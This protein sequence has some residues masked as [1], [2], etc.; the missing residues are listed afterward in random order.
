[1]ALTINQQYSRFVEF[2]SQRNDTANQET[3]ARAG[4]LENGFLGGRAIKVAEGDRVGKARRSDDLQDANNLT[5]KLFR[6][7]I[8]DIFGGMSKIPASVKEAMKLKDYDQGKPLTVRRIMAVKSAIDVYVARAAE[9]FPRAQ[10]QATADGL[11]VGKM[12]APLDARERARIDKLVSTA[13]NAAVSDQDALELVVACGKDIVRGGDGSLRSEEQVKDRVAGIVAN[14]AELKAVAKGNQ[15]VVR[16]GLDFLKA[17]CGKPLPPG[18]IETFVRTTMKQSIG[19]I[20]AL[21]ADSDGIDLHKAVVQMFD[22]F[23]KAGEAADAATVTGREGDV[24]TRFR[25][26]S[27]QLMMIRLGDGLLPGIKTLLENKGS[28]LNSF[29]ADIAGDDMRFD[30]MDPV[31]REYMKRP[32][33]NYINI[34][35]SFYTELQV[36]QGTG[37]DDIKN[38][39]FIRNPNYRN[40]D[41]AGY[42][43]IDA[44][45]VAEDIRDNRAV[46]LMGQDRKFYLQSRVSGKGRGADALRKVF[47]DAQ[48]PAVR[49]GES[50]PD[51]LFDDT[52][53]RNARGLVNSNACML[54]KV[55]VDPIEHFR[56][57]FIGLASFDVIMPDGTAL[58]RN[59]GAFDTLAAF[60]TNG[61]KNSLE[62]LD[63]HERRK[64]DVLFVH[65]SKQTMEAAEK[66]G[67]LAL[68]PDGRDGEKFTCGGGYTKKQFTLSFAN[69]NSVL[70]IKCETERRI[71]TLS[72]R[73]PEG[74]NPAV[75]IGEGSTIS[76]GYCISMP[77][78]E[79]DR[80]ADLDIAGYSEQAVTQKVN[81]P[82]VLKPYQNSRQLLGE[83]Y[84]YKSNVSIST[85]FKITVN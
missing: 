5:R 41:G 57:R 36:R 16:A 54:L 70:V 30:G 12:N 40:P 53:N 47:D 63:E 29:Y 33:R 78:A 34:I 65:V 52:M 23:L 56:A 28:V 74:L 15:A 73:N 45:E 39:P 2:A 37:A 61:R 35:E 18:I 68:D 14:V 48:P 20:K 85:G 11:Y 69:N 27:V 55:N 42:V 4:E 1:M 31:I 21:T 77:V 59:E 17:M 51:K 32:A 50:A 10:A 13:V 44:A 83:Q 46:P 84:A 43:D 25:N 3:I 80:L 19:A 24:K 22:N 67:M 62:A 6:Q 72:V 58:E 71:D 81:D 49:N 64:L 79:L 8:I 76:A 7:S 60:I 38:L 26:F 66:A 82:N 9:A 75:N